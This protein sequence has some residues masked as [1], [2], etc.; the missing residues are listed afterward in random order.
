MEEVSY[1]PAWIEVDLEAIHHN[2]KQ[3]KQQLPEE[4][5]IFAVVKA[6]GYGHGDVEVAK[7]AIA[8]GASMLAVAL[9]E[10]AIQLRNAGITDPILV[11]GWVDPSYVSIAVKHEIT[12]TFFQKSWLDKVK[13]TSFNGKL[14]LHLKLDTGMG[15]IGVSTKKELEEILALMDDSR[16]QLTGAFTHFS[17]ADEADL[18]Y[19]HQQV[20]KWTEFQHILQSYSSDLILHIG[21]S[22]AS[23]RFPKKMHDAVRFGIS[24]YGLYPSGVVK[25]ERP[26]DLVPAMSL[27]TKLIHVK[28]VPAG[29]SI[30]YGATYTTEQS[31]WIGTIPLGYADGIARRL[32][33]MDVLIEGKRM[34]IVGKIC[35]DQC[36]IKLD[37][38]YDIGTRVT[39]IGKQFSEEITM[40]QIAAR[41][42]TIN[43]EI[44]CML[45]DR[46][47]RIYSK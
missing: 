40:D 12:L 42:D 31:E 38:S 33:G 25:E 8:A 15:R 14:S 43:Y 4:T 21:N 16:L 47:P 11:L 7:A 20:E 3:L 39:L 34:P 27:H 26:I 19:Y 17:T 45:S 10:E 41:L 28:Q 18:T 36:M 30:S 32:T 37:Q 46:I 35:M 1:R 6:N 44:A 22:A 24:M 23:M 13:Q 29:S 5:A 2:V 9:L